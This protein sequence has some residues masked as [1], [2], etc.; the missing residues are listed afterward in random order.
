[1]VKESFFVKVIKL[2]LLCFDKTTLIWF[3][4]IC[5]LL[6]YFLE[7]CSC[8]TFKKKIIIDKGA[9]TMAGH[10]VVKMSLTIFR[11][12]YIKIMKKLF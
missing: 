9:A 5:F 12:F 11:T 2:F 6:Y 8:V 4:V 1:M 10:V 7:L 3:E